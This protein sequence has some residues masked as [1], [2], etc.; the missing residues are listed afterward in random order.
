MA[1]QFEL[2]ET[3][4]GALSLRAIKSFLAAAKFNSF[5]RAAKALSVTPA[6]VSKQVRELED[7][8]GTELFGAEPQ[9][10]WPRQRAGDRQVVAPRANEGF[11]FAAVDRSSKWRQAEKF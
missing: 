2:N 5:T 11:T 4:A 6:A 9:L 1:P 3:L 10:V 7:Y 8:L